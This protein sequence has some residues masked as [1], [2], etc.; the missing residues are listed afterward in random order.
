M[1][2][3]ILVPGTVR[4]G[5]V[6]PVDPAKLTEGLRVMILANGDSELAALQSELDAWDRLSDEAWEHIAAL[7]REVKP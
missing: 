5:V 2:T 1:S 4:N 3:R 6:V 7:E